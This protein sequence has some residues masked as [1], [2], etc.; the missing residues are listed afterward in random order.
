MTLAAQ[1][2]CNNCGMVNPPDAVSCCHCAV[3]F[4]ITIPLAPEPVGLPADA[5]V[6]HL[7]AGDLL[8]N[9]Y[10]IHGQVG[11]GGFGAVYKAEDTQKHNRP[12][13]LKEIGLAGLTAQQVIEATG[14]FNREVA[15]LLDLKHESIPRIYA[16]FTDAEHWYLVMDFIEG[17]T[18]E[19][20]RLKS[21]NACL[22]LDET[23]SIGIRLCEVLDYLHSHR[24]PI[25]F[26]DVKPD[27]VMLTPDDRL[28][29]IDYGVARY[30]RAGK[31]RDTIAFGSPGFAP[32][33]QYGKAQTTAQSDIY[34]LGV[35]LYQ[36]LTGVDPS[37]S[38]FRF[39]ALRVLDAAIPEEL[40][41]LVAR[42]LEMDAAKRP[43][44][45]GIVKEQL[46]PISDQRK[47]SLAA[48]RP[49]KP[50]PLPGAFSFSTQGITRYIHRAYRAEVQTAAWSP[51]GKR[52]A[53]AG[54]DRL[55]QV[56]DAF[57]GG[58]LFTYQ[59][60]ADVVNSLCWSPDGRHIA[61]ASRDQTVHIWDAASGRV[62]LRAVALLAGF[63]YSVF[64]GH[65]SEV[66]TLAWSPDGRYI[67]SA[68]NDNSVLVWET[69][70]RNVITCFQAHTDSVQMVA[71]SPDGKHI[72]SASI[73]HTVR[74]WDAHS[75][76]VKFV[77]RNSVSIVHDLSWSPDGRHIALAGSDH[78]VQIWNVQERSKIFTY[79]GHSDSV[80][81]VAWSPDGQYIASGGNDKTVHIWK[82]VHQKTAAGGKSAF[83]YDLHSDTIWS[84]AWS[85]DGQHIASASEDGTVHVWQAI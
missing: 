52:I 74:I 39:P 78:T 48:I 22:T 70:T 31:S 62:W 83:I 18:L 30:F 80:Q 71:W 85:P 76:Q 21:T 53:S 34:S 8:E 24:P 36:L 14:A 23:L 4:K 33:E 47:G 28:Y 29:L 51:D 69:S 61:S 43:A 5:I 35:T 12:V 73:D 6:V 1:R 58:N 2:V 56:W 27:N 67:A 15:L 19:E 16:H 68:G 32:P 37:L 7:K 55:A 10:R 49:L 57:D 81:A 59:N 38:P 79:K 17:V 54:Q 45:M 11:V 42:M 82:A 63:R 25:I 3:S 13:A 60:H 20:Y 50:T 26:R 65:A 75:R 44:S 66:N 77:Y 40:E 46:Q 84:V 72:A 64:E 9:R 41:S